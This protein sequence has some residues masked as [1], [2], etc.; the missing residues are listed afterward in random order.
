MTSNIED[1]LAYAQ[2]QID[3]TDYF[4]LCPESLKEVYATP[5]SYANMGIDSDTNTA[6]V[7]LSNLSPNERIPATVLG[8]K[9]LQEIQ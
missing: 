8:V 5:E 1:M 6:V 3:A 2:I 7:V 9:L 4:E